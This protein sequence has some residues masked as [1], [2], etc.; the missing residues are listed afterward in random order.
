[1]SL[2]DFI[3]PKQC[4]QCKKLGTYICP[5]CFSY[6]SFTDAMVCVIC[7][8]Q[9]MGGITHPVCGTRYSIDGVFPSLVYKG[10]VKKL[11]YTFKYPPYLTSL[12][13]TLSELFYEG[14]IQKEYFYPLTATPSIIIPIPLHVKKFRKRGYNQAQL[15]AEG[16]S[17][18]FGYPLIDALIRVRE[19]QTQVGLSKELRQKNIKDAFAL[20]SELLDQI[21]NVPQVFLVDDVV[22]SGSTLREAAKLLKRA[23]VKKVWGLTLAHGE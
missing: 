15:L 12:Q 14:I 11:V 1:M 2:F 17:K 9:A 7:Q 22:T 20:R 19:T 5:R 4:V 16:I 18:R 21:A 8:R 3:F 13:D 10:I 6:I 23:G